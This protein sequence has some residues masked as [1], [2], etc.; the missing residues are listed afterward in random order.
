MNTLDRVGTNRYSIYTIKPLDQ[1]LNSPSGY[2]IID[3][4]YSATQSLAAVDVITT[5]LL[6]LIAA[7]AVG[8][9]ASASRQLWSFSR[10]GGVPFSRFFAPVC[11]LP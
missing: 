10:N 5:V 9:L 7:A 3:L 6:I 8:T 4:L 1:S 2:P 11:N